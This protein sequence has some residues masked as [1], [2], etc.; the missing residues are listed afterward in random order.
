[1]L[2][3]YM[4]KARVYVAIIFKQYKIEHAETMF[5]ATFYTLKIYNFYV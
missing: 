1:M 2:K 5:I 4:C 3:V